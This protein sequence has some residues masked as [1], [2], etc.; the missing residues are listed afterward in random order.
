MKIGE[1]NLLQV[2]KGFIQ[3]NR[4]PPQKPQ[5]IATG[6]GVIIR[7]SPFVDSPIKENKPNDPLVS[8]KILDSLDLGF[9]EFNQQ[10]R[11]ALAKILNKHN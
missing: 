1:N 2:N 6:T 8:K 11:D 10:E 7:K 3:A 4:K 5:I 9:I